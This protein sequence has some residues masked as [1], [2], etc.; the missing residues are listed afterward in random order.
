LRGDSR[1]LI[2]LAG[3]ELS[4]CEISAER[5]RLDTSSEAGRLVCGRDLRDTT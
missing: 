1:A 2:L 3:F 5:I 4:S